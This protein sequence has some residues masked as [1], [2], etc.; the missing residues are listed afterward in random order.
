MQQSLTARQ[1]AVLLLAEMTLDEKIELMTGNQGE[2]PTAYYNAP[3]AR[4]GIPGLRMADAGGGIADRGWRLPLTGGAAT[5]MPSGASLAATF[6][7]DMATRYAG[8]VADEAKQTG[9]N[10]LLGPNADIVRSPWW[11]R[12]N[13]TESE[14][15]FLTKTITTPYVAAVQDRNVIANLKHYVAYNQ[16]TNRGNSQNTI[17][18]ERALHEVYVAPYADAI[19]EAGLGSIMCSFN[20]INGT[21]ACE[22]SPAL[23]D[24]LRDDLGF[25]GFVITDFGAIHSTVPSIEAGTDLETGTN[26]FYGGALR[27]AVDQGEVPVSLVDRSVLR[28][29]ATMFRVGLFDNDYTATAIPVREHG[30]VARD[31]QEQAVTLL[32][33]TPGTLPVPDTTESIAVIGADATITAGPGGA[34]HVTPTYQVPV[35]DGIRR[36]AAIDG[37]SV[38]YTPGNDP[39]N[40]ANMIEA[41]D[42]TAVPSTVLTPAGGTGT[43]LTADYFDNTTFSGAPDLTRNDK[44]VNY[45]TGFTGGQPAFTTL[46]ASQVPTTPAFDGV[47]GANQSVRYTGTI[48]A[49]TTGSYRL[50]LTGWGD[51]RLFLDNNLVADMTG[52]NG[53]QVATSAQLQLTAGQATPLRVEYAA[54]RPL[55]SLEPGTLLMQWSTPAGAT[56][57][58]IQQAAAAAAA[59]DVAVVYVR[60]YEGEQ[61]D[62]L[63]LKLPQGGDQLIE[64]VR[65]ANPHTVVALASG[66]AVTMPWLD[67]VG[68]VVQNYFGGQEEG[69]AL[70]RVLFGD[71][72]PAGRLPITYPASETAIPVGFG[73]PWASENNR[74]V[75]YSEDVFVGYKGY[76]RADLTP[77]FPFGHGLSYTTFSYSGLT[78][79]PTTKGLDATF[80]VTNT[81]A[82]SGTEVPQVYIGAPSDPEVP[83]P[84]RALVGYDRIEL[85]PGEATKVTVPVKVRDLSYWSVSEHAF[86]LP[87]GARTLEVGPSS[88]D[89]RLRRSNATAGVFSPAPSRA[90]DTNGWYTRPVTVTGQI[91]GVGGNGTCTSR[92][93][94]GPDGRA[95]PVTITCTTPSGATSTGTVR[96]D[97]D[98]TAPVPAVTRPAQA[99]RVRAWAKLR[100]VATTGPG[101]PIVG[102]E[103][104][105]VQRRAAG[106][107]AYVDGRWRPAASRRAAFDRAT[108]LTAT[109]GATRS[110]VRWQRPLPGLRR[111]TLVVRAAATDEAGNTGT[112]TRSQRLTE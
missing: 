47:F 100:G 63:S 81:G 97:Y 111:G 36:R 3:I 14:D 99:T 75:T 90:P 37:V 55:N 88:R 30:R 20:Q 2:A 7:P 85:D 24:V 76:D 33:N 60:T 68:A 50:S 27:A 51:A 62:R 49:P 70:A 42:L 40:A 4:L 95:V 6:N 94:S 35:L 12:I 59:A 13:E 48:T 18:G 82:V 112:R 16:E 23:D 17:V 19:A 5:A 101:S 46:Y 105:A 28:I 10:M 32:K 93:Y 54:T 73:S 96:I 41:T 86:R 21:F 1:R 107:F 84:R 26:S 11:G 69:G 64:A 80:T 61:R 38:T 71:V 25:T 108:P 56:S 34:P 83:M 79:T 67:G 9:H 8:V 109:L 66:G 45:D 92:T 58:G 43:G 89:L 102:V 72:N 44:Q 22:S 78:V 106:W 104:S 87:A 29:L 65:A 91:A 39:V 15:P 74:D 110:G 53:R 57:P 31:V 103:V 77:L 52:A 98:A